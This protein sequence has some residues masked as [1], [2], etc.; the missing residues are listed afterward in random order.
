M[1]KFFFVF[2]LLLSSNLFQYSEENPENYPIGIKE[3]HN[4]LL[5]KNDVFVTD[6]R[7]KI[8]SQEL[9]GFNTTIDSLEQTVQKLIK[10]YEGNSE[11]IDTRIIDSLLTETTFVHKRYRL[12][13]P[14]NYHRFANFKKNAT[15]S[16]DYFENVMKGSFDNPS[17][18]Q[19]KHYK[20]CMN[21]YFDILSAGKYK[22][23]H[24]EYVPLRR[25]DNRYDAIAELDAHQSVKDFFIKEHFTSNIWTYR[26]EAFDYAFAKALKDVK[27]PT[28]IKKIKDTYQM[29][30]DRRN[31]TSEIKVYKTVDDITL[32]AHIFYPE[33][34]DKTQPK[35]AHLFFNG[36]GWAIGLP[37]W[38]Y[39]AC[40][41]AAK[42]GRVAIAFDYRK[43]NVYGT[44]VKAS[45]SDAL[46]A[47]A[48][49]RE[50]AKEL[51]IDPNKIVADG[52]S[53]GAHLALVS[54]MIE[55]R[56]DFGVTSKYS[57]KPNA[58]ILGSCPYD[59]AGR[60]V[61]NVSYDTK[62]ISPLYLIKEN[63]PPIL[64]FH[65]EEDD[66]VEFSEFEK[67][68]DAIQETKN[69]F[70]WRSYTG[71]RHFYF[72]GSSQKDS[73]ERRKLREEFLLK[74]GFKVK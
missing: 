55:N 60:D 49:V 56:E 8:F 67:F 22:F 17:L 40:Q 73:D 9:D 29:G 46:A 63:L 69:S 61:Y 64:A 57:S 36:G 33:N 26:V 44:D 41:G 74:N 43:R 68:R 53:A 45:V 47:I 24:L 11:A 6:N 31:A 3:A 71:A 32:S 14:N 70:T 12:L 4:K 7:G 62:M 65:G 20:R 13:Y 48:W 51:G 37:E 2:V 23:S 39:G 50:N 15:V 58:I 28:Y 18:V 16:K 66:M 52:F 25:L 27:N 54:S 30:K 42:D 38:S 1:H 10:K 72:E 59:I 34:H 5:K 35:P 21:Y 19:F